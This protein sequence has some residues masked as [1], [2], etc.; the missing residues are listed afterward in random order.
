[1]CFSYKYVQ[2]T[3]ELEDSS[4]SSNRVA[5]STARDTSSESNVVY[6]IY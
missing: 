1:M 5:E 3:F 4:L 6:N 2:K